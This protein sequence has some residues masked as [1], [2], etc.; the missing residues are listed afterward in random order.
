MK[1]FQFKLQAVLTLRQRAEHEALAH[2]ARM[3]QAGQAAREKL[4]E[5][6]AQLSEARRRWLHALADGIL[7]LV[8]VGIAAYSL[9][10]DHES[11]DKEPV[12]R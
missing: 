7:T 8:A 3:L 11:R 2:Y 10:R 6:E 12:T 4:A 1:R 5:S 9:L